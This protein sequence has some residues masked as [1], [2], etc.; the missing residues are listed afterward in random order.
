MV[1]TKKTTKMQFEE[2]LP[3]TYCMKFC[4]DCQKIVEK[5]KLCRDSVFK[6]IEIERM[7][8]SIICRECY[9]YDLQQLSVTM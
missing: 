5:K 4:L 9:G 1:K 7:F 8:K 3:D 2:S 6:K